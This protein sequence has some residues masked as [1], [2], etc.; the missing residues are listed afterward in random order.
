M[1]GVT[2][3]DQYIP[4]SEIHTS[5]HMVFQTKNNKNVPSWA[6]YEDELHFEMLKSHVN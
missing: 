4:P 3:I 5:R 2:T 1:I 6:H